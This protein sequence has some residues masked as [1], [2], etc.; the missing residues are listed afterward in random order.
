M[1]VSYEQAL[2]GNVILAQANFGDVPRPGSPGRRFLTQCLLAGA[3][4][5]NN[6]LQV[7]SLFHQFLAGRAWTWNPAVPGASY[8][9]GARL[10][11]GA[12]NAGECGYPAYAL[13]YL[14]NAP[15]PYGF[16]VGGAAV[17]T[18]NGQHNQ[19][20][21]SNHANALPGPQPN[22]TRPQGGTLPAYYYWDNHKV[23]QFQNQYY[24]PNY[25]AVYVNPAAMAAADLQLVRQG[26][27]LRDLENYN[28][29]SPWS[30]LLGWGLPRL[31]A[32]KVSDLAFG[33]AHDISVYRAIGAAPVSGY[34]ME[35]VERWVRPGGM[36]GTI[37]GPFAHSPLVR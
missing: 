12:V 8:T 6:M 37:Y 9:A 17:V 36:R 33:T 25:R 31:A 19:G 20:F 24:D 35:W 14:I 34:Y 28:P 4:P 29:L 11:D 3:T 5:A 16:G 2:G 21:I 23:V 18:Y 30:F 13:A 22:I 7:N 10:L 27:R 1:P 32:L 26:V 15:P